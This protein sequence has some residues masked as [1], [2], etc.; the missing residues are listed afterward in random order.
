MI[1][2]FF[3]VGIVADLFFLY[4][5]SFTK[6]EPEVCFIKPGQYSY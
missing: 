4:V 6:K 1:T 3:F 2:Q 5:A